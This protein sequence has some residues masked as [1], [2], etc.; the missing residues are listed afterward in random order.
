MIV[1]VIHVYVTED[2][3]EAF[4]KAT[5]ENHEG[6]VREPGVLRFDVLLD[7]EDA[8]HFILYEAYAS[9]EATAAHKE[10]EHY[11]KWKKAVESMM[12]APRKGYT[13][14]VAAPTNPADWRMGG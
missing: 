11:K 7:S 6:S 4:K 1:R 2:S 8:T 12:A 10:T 14:S 13:C 5:V 9:Q 3:V